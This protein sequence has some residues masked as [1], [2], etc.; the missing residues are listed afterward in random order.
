MESS[1]PRR[2]PFLA[3]LLA[4]A[5]GVHFKSG[6]YTAALDGGAS[7]DLSAGHPDREFRVRVVGGA[8]EQRE[9]SWR[10]ESWLLQLHFTD[11][12]SCSLVL[13]SKGIR[14]SSVGQ[15]GG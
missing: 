1:F 10:H 14:A 13:H 12:G 5:G 15:L 3:C 6:R 11:F 8:S 9:Q 7:L 4:T 2:A